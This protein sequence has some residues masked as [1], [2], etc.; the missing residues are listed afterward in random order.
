MEPDVTPVQ[1]GWLDKL[2]ME[3]AKDDY[4]IQGSAYRGKCLPDK[5]GKCDAIG[6]DIIG[7]INGNALWN[8]GDLTFV[9]FMYEVAN[10]EYMHW[11]FDLAPLM[12]MQ[13]GRHQSVVSTGRFSSVE[14]SDVLQ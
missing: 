9:K 3:A 14:L 7:H 12:H 1:P 10:G 4:W 11:P 8:V 2:L 6:R 5:E 13:V